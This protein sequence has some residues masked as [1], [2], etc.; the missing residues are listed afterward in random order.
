MLNPSSLS[1]GISTYRDTTFIWFSLSLFSCPPPNIYYP[2]EF[3]LCLCISSA[4][5]I[6]IF[7]TEKAL[8]T[9]LFNEQMNILYLFFLHILS[10][11]PSPSSHFQLT[12]MSMTVTSASSSLQSS[13]SLH[14][15]VYRKKHPR[16]C[17][18]GPEN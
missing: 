14:P 10:G 7:P 11:R 12:F 4:L 5:F 1:S 17:P 8:Y 16:G 6:A 15:N 2:V 3:N 13:K 18:K 9:Y